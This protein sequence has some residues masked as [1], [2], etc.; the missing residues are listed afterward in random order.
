MSPPDAGHT[1]GNASPTSPTGFKSNTTPRGAVLEAL[2]PLLV[3]LGH[4]K[5][6][7]EESAARAQQSATE[8]I[9]CSALLRGLEAQGRFLAAAAHYD[10]ETGDVTLLPDADPEGQETF[11]LVL[12]NPQGATLSR[13]TIV[14]TVVELRVTGVTVDTVLTFN[15]LAGRRYLVEKSADGLNWT[16]LVNGRKISRPSPVPMA[17]AGAPSTERLTGV[18]LPPSTMRSTRAL[19]RP[20]LTTRPTRPSGPTTGCPLVTPS[21]APADNVA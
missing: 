3:T 21:E 17:R 11:S 6:R 13:S 7:N 19:T 5:C 12:S 10:L 14:C 20:T 1:N 2:N 15:T 4:T 9:Q 18:T 16:P 8:A